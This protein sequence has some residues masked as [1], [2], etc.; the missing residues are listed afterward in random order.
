MIIK[1][2]TF[3]LLILFI[4]SSVVTAQS[5]YSIGISP[6]MAEVDINPGEQ[7]MI[8]FSIVTQSTETIF[9]DLK[10]SPGSINFFPGSRYKDK[11]HNYSEQAVHEWLTP[12]ESPIEIIPN[13]DATTPNIRGWKTVSLL[14]DVPQEIEP[15]YHLINVM[16]APAVSSDDMQ[17]G[18]TRLVA[19]VSFNVLFKVPGEATRKGKI[20]DTVLKNYRSTEFDLSTF[21]KNTGTVT[22]TARAI[23]HL[24]DI[25]GTYLGEFKSSKHKVAP[26]STTVMSAPVRLALAEGNYS[27]LTTVDYI[28]NQT[29]KYANVTVS[30]DLL[31]ITGRLIV[32]KE[33]IPFTLILLIIII[34]LV[35]IVIYK[36]K[37][38][39]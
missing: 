9:V 23:Q 2:I 20:L 1:H 11:I 35:I 33:Q 19:V 32:E 30:E 26:G 5:K 10:T 25:N 7:K 27:V 37:K 8:A 34:I 28:T 17:A 15:G 18:G 14:L 16:P 31:H 6:N 36:Y 3:F 22:M 12:T 39:D 24:Y 38:S 29:E 13:P 21:F 4:F